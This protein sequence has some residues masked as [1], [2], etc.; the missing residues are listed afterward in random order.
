MNAEGSCGEVNEGDS[1]GAGRNSVSLMFHAFGDEEKCPLRSDESFLPRSPP[2]FP[3]VH[4]HEQTVGQDARGEMPSQKKFLL[5][6]TEE[7]NFGIVPNPSPLCQKTLVGER[8]E[9]TA[10]FENHGNLTTFNRT[11]F[12]TPLRLSFWG[13][14]GKKMFA[15][16]LYRQQPPTQTL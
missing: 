14:I 3:F 16:A 2:D 6:R 7:V 15:F 8:R 4:Q 10:R 1:E 13:E 5:P 9:L 11:N 12:A